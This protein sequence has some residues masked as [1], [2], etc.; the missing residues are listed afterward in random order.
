MLGCLG[1][2]KPIAAWIR[3]FGQPD[4]QILLTSRG[5]LVQAG[6]STR[7]TT[8]QL[9][10]ADGRYSSFPRLMRETGEA[11]S[12]PTSQDKSAIRE[13]KSDDSVQSVSTR[14]CSPLTIAD[15]S[16]YGIAQCIRLMID[17]SYAKRITLRHAELALPEQMQEALEKVHRISIET[18]IK[19]DGE[20]VGVYLHKGK[21]FTV[22]LLSPPFKDDPRAREKHTW[23]EVC[24]TEIPDTNWMEHV[25]GNKHMKVIFDARRRAIRESE[26]LPAEHPPP[27]ITLARDHVWCSVC[28]IQVHQLQ[29]KNH[30]KTTLFRKIL[31]E[32]QLMMP[33]LD[34]QLDDVRRVPDAGSRA[35][36]KF[37]IN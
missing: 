13:M 27:E 4:F 18:L 32:R 19:S 2:N 30:T 34:E 11:L 33:E 15:T 5:H 10:E 17:R 28:S 26:G 3:E 36:S 6:R 9:D 35:K 24:Q 23:C 22:L 1:P 31:K 25:T 16:R 14:K 12:Y 8:E 37:K 7:A 21:H 20:S 29:F